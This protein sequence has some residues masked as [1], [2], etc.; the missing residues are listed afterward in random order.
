V[1]EL[2]EVGGASPCWI[3]ILHG[4]EPANLPVQ[5]P[6]TYET[7]I[8]LKTAKALGLAVTLAKLLHLQVNSVTV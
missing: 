2:G 6:T 1:T 3:R 4:E 7:T 5:T 8:N